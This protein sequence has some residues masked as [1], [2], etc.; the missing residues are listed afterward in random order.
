MNH[1]MKCDNEG[2]KGVAKTRRGRAEGKEASSFRRSEIKGRHATGA[3]PGSSQAAGCH[4]D[5]V[6]VTPKA[7]VECGMERRETPH[8]VRPWA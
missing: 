2:R 7:T 5:A 4:E 8:L 3:A 6:A 1:E